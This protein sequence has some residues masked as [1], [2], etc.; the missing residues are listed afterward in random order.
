MRGR[1]LNLE[2]ATAPGEGV[3]PMGHGSEARPALILIKGVHTLVFLAELG[4]IGWLLVSGLLG[5]RD[6][7]VAIAAV[8]VAAEAAVFLAN[9]GVCPLTPLAERH[10]A[11]NGSVSDIFLPDVV[12]RTVRVR[13]DQPTGLRP[14]DRAHVIQVTVEETLRHA[15]DHS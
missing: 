2:P 5:R 9:D 12:A 15:A 6:R 13:L 1:P 3:N 11:A 8:M 14:E 10:G 4:A 7:T